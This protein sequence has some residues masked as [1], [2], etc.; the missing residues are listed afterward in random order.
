MF[1][2]IAR[3]IERTWYELGTTLVRPWY[4]LGSYKEKRQEEDKICL[5]K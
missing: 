4:E 3:E 2:S 1:A 5:L